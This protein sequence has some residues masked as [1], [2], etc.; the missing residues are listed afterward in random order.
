MQKYSHLPQLEVGI[1]F[2]P[3]ICFRLNGIFTCRTTGKKYTGAYNI[4]Q[5]EDGYL[6]SQA[7][8]REPVSLPLTFE[9]EDDTTSDFD[10][11]DVVIGIQFHWERKENQW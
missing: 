5:T 2:S 9:P 4:R 10:L 8:H 11:T 6:L 3:E 1:L 7:D